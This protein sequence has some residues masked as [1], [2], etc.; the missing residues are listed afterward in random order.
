MDWDDLKPKPPKGITLGESLESLSVGEL[1]A[2]IAALHAGDRARAGRAG[3]QEGARGGGCRHLQAV[4]RATARP[5]SLRSALAAH[6]RHA[7]SQRGTGGAAVAARGRLFREAMAPDRAVRALPRPLRRTARQLIEVRGSVPTTSSGGRQ[8]RSVHAFAAQQLAE[9][10]LWRRRARLARRV[11]LGR[12]AGEGGAALSGR[13][14]CW[15]GKPIAAQAQ[16]DAGTGLFGC[17][18]PSAGCRLRAAQCRAAR[19][20][21]TVC[22]PIRVTIRVIQSS[23]SSGSCPLCLTPPC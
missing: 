13:P 8:A 19:H 12:R 11:R 4:M 2:R 9:G 17:R 23:G 21:F 20:C 6:L 15:P 5:P 3:G 10:E 18:R 7:A 14:R 1:E 16:P 22:Y